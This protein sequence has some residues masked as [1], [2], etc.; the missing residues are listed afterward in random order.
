MQGHRVHTYYV[1]VI[2]LSPCIIYTLFS[3]KWKSFIF[4]T[5]APLFDK[6]NYNISHTESRSAIIFQAEK[7]APVMT[8]NFFDA[9]I[10][11]NI[12]T[13]VHNFA[14]ILIIISC[15]YY[16]CTVLILLV[17]VKCQTLFRMWDNCLLLQ[18]YA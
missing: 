6:N 8:I 3:Q 14:H 1:H 12:T 5:C 11:F 17:I 18:T 15:T 10:L 7:A 9:L 4:S 13:F 16:T 2:P